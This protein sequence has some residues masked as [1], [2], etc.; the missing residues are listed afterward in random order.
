M[1]YKMG[2]CFMKRRLFNM[3]MFFVILNMTVSASFYMMTYNINDDFIQTADAIMTFM[4][5]TNGDLQSN[6]ILICTGG[7]GN[8]S[9]FNIFSRTDASTN[10]LER[11]I[12]E[13]N[14]TC[15]TP[16]R[17]ELSS[18]LLKDLKRSFPVVVSDSSD[19]NGIRTHYLFNFNDREIGIFNITDVPSDWYE[20]VKGEVDLFE[21]DY[22]IV[23]MDNPDLKIVP[24]ELRSRTF[25]VPRDQAVYRVETDFGP[26]LTELRLPVQTGG[27]PLLKE[28]ASSYREWLEKEF[29][30]DP[31][32]LTRLQ[33]IP[34]YNMIGLMALKDADAD[35]MF[36]YNQELP[37]KISAQEAVSLFNDYTFG[38]LY[39]ENANIR[40]IL[41]RSAAM[42]EYDGFQ[43]EITDNGNYYSI[44]GEPYYLDISKI[45][46]RRLI[47]KTFQ[48]PQKIL[49]FG[50]E[51]V[52][53]ENF[54]FMKETDLSPFYYIFWALR[55]GNP[56]IEPSWRVVAQPYLYT[57]TVQK[58]DTINR[59]ADKFDITPASIKA[60]NPDLIEMYLSTGEHIRIHIPYP[61]EKSK[62]S[63]D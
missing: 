58:G 47:I 26:S 31:D 29:T 15:I 57:Y 43:T 40:K 7:V 54:P 48:Q 14:T 8:F 5:K 20:N 45:P 49:V 28:A 42:I 55:A 56:A 41:E 10:Y 59:I 39:L 22:I 30:L 16:G 62:E 36:Y 4:E 1:M 6:P 23:I 61:W 34:L 25:A 38:T 24:Q 51:P 35:L 17:N 52:L 60:F 3:I 44:Y 50:P 46:G 19:I 32:A 37:E 63:E 13:I 9:S 11:I 53:R 2:G 21:L 18:T 33:E 27:Y 12:R